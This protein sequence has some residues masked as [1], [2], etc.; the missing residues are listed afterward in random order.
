MRFKYFRLTLRVVGLVQRE[1][2]VP[3]QV[4]ARSKRLGNSDG[5]VQGINDLVASPHTL[6]LSS[7]DET[8]VSNLEL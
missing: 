3:D 8:R 6:V 5:P 7:G 1:K 4:L 2:L